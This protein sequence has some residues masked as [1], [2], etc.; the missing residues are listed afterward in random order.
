MTSDAERVLL[1]LADRFAVRR[2]IPKAGTSPLSCPGSATVMVMAFFVPAGR[3]AT[4]IFASACRPVFGA[5]DLN[6]TRSP[7]PSSFGCEIACFGLRSGMSRGL[8]LLD[9]APVDR[10]ETTSQAAELW[11]RGGVVGR[12]AR[13]VDGIGGAAWS[14]DP[15]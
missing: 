1:K 5:A 2:R 4:G 8:L 12:E 10:R 7:A 13:M 14:N 9:D 11:R 15:K 3:I 6:P